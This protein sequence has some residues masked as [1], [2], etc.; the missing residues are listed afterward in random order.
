MSAVGGQWKGEAVILRR[1]SRNRL[2]GAG[3]QL[4]AS[5]VSAT[6]TIVEWGGR[7]SG[8]VLKT[9]HCR[10][11]VGIVPGHHW[12][13]PFQGA[14]PHDHAHSFAHKPC[15]TRTR[16]MENDFQVGGSM[17]RT[18]SS[19]P[20]M[21]FTIGSLCVWPTWVAHQTPMFG[22]S[23]G[24][25]Y[26]I[27]AFGGLALSGMSRIEGSLCP[28]GPPRER[29][30]ASLPQLA[31]AVFFWGSAMGIFHA[32]RWESETSAF[33]RNARGTLGSQKDI[34][35]ARLGQYVSSRDIVPIEMPVCSRC[36]E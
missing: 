3:L 25:C 6:P 11:I 9:G 24:C 28:S 35:R 4:S 27:M 12:A 13:T 15:T 23:I 5:H 34:R 1:G 32:G 7:T 29:R 22:R 14:P 19:V 21:L 30:A 18:P 31:S 2:R 36:L 10:D 26:S 8:L 16:N 33:G 17:K 20:G